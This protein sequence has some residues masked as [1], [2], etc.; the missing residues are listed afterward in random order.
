M[1]GTEI[2]PEKSGIVIEPNLQQ[3]TQLTGT[4]G[5][6]VAKQNQIIKNLLP[7]IQDKSEGRKDKDTEVDLN[8]IVVIDTKRRRPNPNEKLDL[9]MITSPQEDDP[10]NQK[11]LFLAVSAL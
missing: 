8:E 1:A 3:E 5:G 11:N 7:H 4:V 9:D 6:K 10:T 2:I